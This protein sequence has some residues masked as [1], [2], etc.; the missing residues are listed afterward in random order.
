MIYSLCVNHYFVSEKPMHLLTSLRHITSLSKVLSLYHFYKSDTYPL[1]QD[2]LQQRM[3]QREDYGLC[4][5][6][7]IGKPFVTGICIALNY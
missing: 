2:D 4:P 3:L 1:V 6:S 7:L 5:R